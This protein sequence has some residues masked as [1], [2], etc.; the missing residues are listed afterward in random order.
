[1]KKHFVLLTILILISVSFI[2]IPLSEPTEGATRGK[3]KWTFMVYLDADNNLEGAGVEDMNEM[4]TVGSTDEVNVVVQF[5]R[6]PEYDV[7][8]GDWTDT[9]RFLVMKDDDKETITSPVIEE[10]GEINMGDPESLID[11]IKWSVDN[12]PAENYALSLWNHGGAFRGICW[13]DTG[14]GSTHDAI[15]MPE[16]RY[17]LMEAREYIGHNFGLIGFDACLMANIAVLYELQGITDYALA[18]GYNEPGDGWPYER[19]LPPLVENPDMTALELGEVMADTY[20][21][22][23]TD[24]AGDPDDAWAITMSV[25]EMDKMPTAIERLNEFAMVLSTSAMINNAQIWAARDLTQSYDAANVGPFDFTGYAMYDVIGFLE[26]IRTLAPLNSDLTTAASAAIEGIYEFIA[27]ARVDEFH[28]ADS[29]GL[30]IYFPNTESESVN[31]PGRNDYD[32]TFDE[33]SFAKEKYWDEFLFH[34]FR[35]ENAGNTPP[36]GII[37][38]PANDESIMASN[39]LYTIKGTAFDAQDK[40]TIE[41]RID[42]GEWTA[43]TE[44]G[45][46]PAGSIQWTYEWDVEDLEGE[47]T[48]GL[49]VSDADGNVQEISTIA[50]VEVPEEEEKEAGET[51]YTFAIIGAI[52]LLVLLFIAFLVMRMRQM[53]KK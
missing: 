7:T 45:T 9:K 5:D 4:E 24:R 19:F 21:D 44:S 23:Y 26:H 50:F 52:I 37:I 39:S 48:L 16:M 10:M 53:Q 49:R 13:D 35:K 40:P 51:S 29:N 25:F 8:N 18:S 11:F 42:E 41:L 38:N 34:Y 12:Y 15:T 2:S 1:M 33:V 20:V 6:I 47:Y 31:V 36:T 30:T 17:A 14:D 3:A 32:E 46:T 22:S 43:V 27:Y 28:D